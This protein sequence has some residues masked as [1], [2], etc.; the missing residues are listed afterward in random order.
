VA[1]R[2]KRTGWLVIEQRYSDS[3]K[4]IRIP[5][6][7]TFAKKE[8]ADAKRESMTPE[9]GGELFSIPRSALVE[10]KPHKKR[11][12]DDRRRPRH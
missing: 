5:R 6:S 12:R 9:H 8:D 1:E 3:G 2:I 11:L 10:E 4:F 7:Q